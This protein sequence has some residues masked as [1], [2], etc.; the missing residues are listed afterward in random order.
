MDFASKLKQARNAAGLTQTE[1]AQAA[2]VS[3]QTLS[4]WENGRSIPDIVSVTHLANLYGITLD[5]LVRE[6]E[7]AP[8]EKLTLLQR[9]WD[10]LYSAAV[11]TIPAAVL[12]GQFLSEWVAVLLLVLGAVVYA[13]PRVLYFR[14]FGCTLKHLILGLLGW[15]LVF[16]R[17][18]WMIGGGAFSLV[19]HLM[20]MTGV[21]LV[22]YGRLQ[23]QGGWNSRQAWHQ[24]VVMGLMVLSLVL[25]WMDDAADAGSFN[26]VNPFEH[27][28]RIAAVEYGEQMDGSLVELGYDHELRFLDVAADT[29]QGMGKFV[30][31]KPA[32]GDEAEALAGIWEL[33]SPEDAG[34]RYRLTVDSDGVIRL[35]HWKNEVLQYRWRLERA[36][37]LR[38]SLKTAGAVSSGV[39]EWFPAGSFDGNPDRLNAATIIGSS[40]TVSIVLEIPAQELT[41]YERRGDRETERSLIPNESGGFSLEFRGEPGEILICRIPWADGDYWFAVEFE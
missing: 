19:A 28:Y 31:E 8:E 11:V 27:P 9:N 39:L 32:E 29:V 6:P 2:Q 20:M 15:T 1:A 25:P 24:W 41:L 35:S 3:R 17:T 21:G 38:W 30:Y 34:V 4:S 12:A 18:I 23:E 40:G 26:A 22:L 5:E 37:G 36:D 14:L 10:L 16:L 13:L 7:D 33:V